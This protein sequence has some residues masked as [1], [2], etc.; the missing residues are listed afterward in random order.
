MAFHRE[1]WA[2]LIVCIIGIS[3]F[4]LPYDVVARLLRAR[5]WKLPSRLNYSAYCVHY[6]V[7]AL[8]LGLRSTAIHVSAEWLI[9]DAVCFIGLSYV[10]AFFMYVFVFGTHTTFEFKKWKI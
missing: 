8:G 6:G 10:A 1:L 2:L 3:E 9:F 4:I 7:I 5:L